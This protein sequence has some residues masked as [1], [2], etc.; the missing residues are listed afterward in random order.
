MFGTKN[1][2]TRWLETSDMVRW[3]IFIPFSTPERVY[4]WRFPQKINNLDCIWLFTFNRG[5][6]RRFSNDFW[7]ISWYSGVL[8]SH[9]I[10]EYFQ[11]IVLIF[12]L[13]THYSSIFVCTNLYYLSM[14]YCPYAHICYGEIVI[15][16]RR[17]G[18]WIPPLI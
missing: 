7:T 10:G 13:A 4:V 9:Y 16:K 2:D 14:L 3:I 1:L 15:W 18:S 5:S 8:S 11:L 17:K 6:W 12:T